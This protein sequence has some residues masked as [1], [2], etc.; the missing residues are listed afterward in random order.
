MLTGLV[1]LSSFIGSYFTSS[2]NQINPDSTS[3]T[4]RDQQ[5]SK[6]FEGPTN[7]EQ[8]NF[9]DLDNLKGNV[10]RCRSDLN[11]SRDS[12]E[13]NEK[14]KVETQS[15]NPEN[16]TNSEHNSQDQIHSREDFEY[17]TG[18]QEASEGE[19]EFD[20][21]EEVKKTE[22]RSEKGTDDEEYYYNL[23]EEYYSSEE[24][25]ESSLEDRSDWESVFSSQKSGVRI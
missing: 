24:E 4:T 21:I 9:E 5:D 13:P 25:E 3:S 22:Y 8:Q 6:I 15:E 1:G 17:R 12:I 16:K 23:R 7:S 19:T 20:S 11:N 2:A 18:S 14:L 10:S